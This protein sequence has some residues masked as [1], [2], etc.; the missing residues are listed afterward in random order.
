MSID[1]FYRYNRGLL[2][3]AEGSQP[4]QFREI[5]KC[6][7]RK[8]HTCGKFVGASK[9]CFVACPST[10]EMKFILNIIAE[11]LTKIGIK[12]IIAIEQRVYGQD[13]LCTKI[14]GKIIESQFCIVLL[15]DTVEKIHSTTTNIPNPNVYYEYGL[16][17]ALGKHV[18]P[19]QK[20]GQVTLPHSIGHCG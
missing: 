18:I 1:R 14:C 5:T 7:V 9:S 6:L 4:T 15:D 11:K 12:P 19:L 17:T 3:L 2:T 20:D 16:M 13:I 10:Q 8:D